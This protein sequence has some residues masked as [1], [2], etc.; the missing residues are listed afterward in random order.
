MTF[1]KTYFLERHISAVHKK[2][3]PYVCRT[4][5][6]GFSQKNNCLRHQG[7]NHKKKKASVKL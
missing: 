7:L 5:G 2:E 6:D 4:C 1:K 3:K